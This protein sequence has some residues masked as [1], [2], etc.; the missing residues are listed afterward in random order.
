MQ[1]KLEYPA[2]H[3][4]ATCARRVYIIFMIGFNG[5]SSRDWNPIFDSY[6]RRLGVKRRID[7]STLLQTD[8]NMFS[9]E[10]G[11]LHEPS[12]D[13]LPGQLLSDNDSPPAL[14]RRKLLS[15]R[16]PQNDSFRRRS[17]NVSSR[18]HRAAEKRRARKNERESVRRKELNG[19]FWKLHQVLN[20]QKTS[21]AAMLTHACELIV[22]LRCENQALVSQNRAL[23]MRLAVLDPFLGRSRP[24]VSPVF[25]SPPAAFVPEFTPI[26]P[27]PAVSSAT[28][29]QNSVQKKE[30][31]VKAL[32]GDEIQKTGR[33]PPQNELVSA[34]SS[35]LKNLASSKHGPEGAQV[36]RDL[37]T[38]LRRNVDLMDAGAIQASLDRLMPAENSKFSTYCTSGVR[39]QMYKK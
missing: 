21:R 33:N 35:S 15:S 25:G 38:S 14:K 11:E 2:K 32:C 16:S 12:S 34:L 39:H 5:L 22:Q 17:T 10:L 28:P 9:R 8:N 19:G 23:M 7:L 3:Q 29:K 4:L 30:H 31:V 36:L 1:C 18:I 24:I 26:Q 37:E 27:T 13:I 6:K 20:V